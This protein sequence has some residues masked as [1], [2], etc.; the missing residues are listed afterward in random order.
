MIKIGDLLKYTT[1]FQRG[2]IYYIYLGE[3][4]VEN[5]LYQKM[6][7]MNGSCAGAIEQYWGPRA[8][9]ESSPYW[10]V[11]SSLEKE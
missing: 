8:Y 9:Y 2:E 7:A 3:G 6:Y 1:F 5:E 10:E 4:V 11:I